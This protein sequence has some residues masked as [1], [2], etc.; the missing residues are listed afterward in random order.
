[1]TVPV[2]VTTVSAPSMIAVI[3]I[4]GMVSPSPGIIIP[5]IPGPAA[6]IPGRIIVIVTVETVI[7]V[8]APGIVVPGAVIPAAV[9]PRPIVPPAVIV[10]GIQG[11]AGA[12]PGV[13]PSPCRAGIHN[14]EPC[15]RRDYKGIS[16]IENIGW[17]LF[18]LC[19]EIIHFFVHV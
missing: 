9:I 15:T 7:T 11:P 19:Q 1:M 14:G 10:P 17:R 16:L 3:G 2:I 5:G 18:T 4:I 6:V 13:F 12:V 8:V